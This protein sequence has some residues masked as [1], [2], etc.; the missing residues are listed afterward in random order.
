[1]GRQRL[2]AFAYTSIRRFTKSLNYTRIYLR[3]TSIRCRSECSLASKQ[4]G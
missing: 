1:L 3:A 4:L 2:A